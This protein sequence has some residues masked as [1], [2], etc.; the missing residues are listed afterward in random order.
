MPTYIA[1]L[2]TALLVGCYYDEGLEIDNLHGTV[3]LPET[4]AQRTIVVDGTDELV[5]DVRLIGPVILGLYP[6]VGND[7]FG[8]S[9]PVTGPAFNSGTTGDTFPYGGTT[10]GDVRFACMQALTCKVSSGRF[11]D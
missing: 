9:H 1:P 8:Y 6:A 10:V 5:T 11:V 7:Q 2:A 4:A 3:V